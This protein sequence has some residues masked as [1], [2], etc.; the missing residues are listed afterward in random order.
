MEEQA[1]Y[2]FKNDSLL[3]DYHTILTNNL[4]ELNAKVLEESSNMVNTIYL[5]Q[6]AVN[7]NMQFI[8]EQGEDIFRLHR[9]WHYGIDTTYFENTKTIY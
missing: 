4:N 2:A 7:S 9:W 8:D 1:D 5:L 3:L 6:Q